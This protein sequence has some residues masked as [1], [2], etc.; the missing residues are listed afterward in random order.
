MKQNSI[1]LFVFTSVCFLSISFSAGAQEEN[2]S[3][4]SLPAVVEKLSQDLNLFR[5]LKISGYI[6]AQYQKADTCGIKSFAGGDFPDNANQRFMVRRGRLKVNYNGHLSQ[7]V[8]QLDVTEKGIGTKDVYAMFTD[9][10]FNAISLTAGLFNRPFGYEITYSSSQRESPE[11]ARIYQTLF[12]GERDGGM[13]ITFQ[14]PKASNFN[15]LRF[16]AGFFNGTGIASDFDSKKDLIT[17]LSVTRTNLSET[18]KYGLGLSYYLGGWK[19]G[20]RYYYDATEKVA[21]GLYAFRL[22]STSTPQVVKR[23]YFGADMQFTF[24]NPLGLTTIRGEYLC[25]QQPGTASTSISPGSQPKEATITTVNLATGK[26]SSSTPNSSAFIRKFQ[27]ALF[28]VTQNIL[29]SK[30]QLVFKYDFYD[31]NT[32]VKGSEIGNGGIPA[33]YGPL[34]SADVMYRTY[35]IGYIFKWDANVKI[36]VYYDIVRNES[37]RLQGYSSDLKDNVF[38]FRIQ[39]KF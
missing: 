21:G 20:N 36:M 31:P 15:W 3:P 5:N 14:P 27:G 17:H 12:P 10:W 19:N 8:I 24:E 9:P 32:K 30:H 2:S 25:G 11:R 35:G 26:V 33:S 22:D 16:D 6:Q 34:T 29:Q 1:C 18:I 28:Y 13:M 39:Y 38:T 37:T 4:D 23:E 7:Y